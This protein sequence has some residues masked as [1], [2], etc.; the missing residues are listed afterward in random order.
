MRNEDKNG[1][2]SDKNEKKNSKDPKLALFKPIS[3]SKK[4]RYLRMRKSSL[5]MGL[6]PENLILKNQSGDQNNASMQ[7]FG[8]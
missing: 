7:L 4:K 3:S 6:F 8:K 5:N 2:T 1:N